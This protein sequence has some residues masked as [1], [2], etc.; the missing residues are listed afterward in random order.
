VRRN[1]G[2][3]RNHGEQRREHLSDRATYILADTLK[4]LA[5]LPPDSIHAVVTDPPYGLVEYDEKN[6]K[7]FR[8][9]HAGV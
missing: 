7:K 6:H 4:W 5:D 2:R 9:G 8:A 1:C 3:V